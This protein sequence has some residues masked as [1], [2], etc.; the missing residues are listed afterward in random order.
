MSQKLVRKKV[1]RPQDENE[2]QLG[3][4][5]GASD[6]IGW[7]VVALSHVKEYCSYLDQSRFS[8]SR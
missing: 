4:R 8:P 2:G 1:L 7:V 6:M 3:M 5:L